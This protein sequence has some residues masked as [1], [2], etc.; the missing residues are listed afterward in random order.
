M[1][2]MTDVFTAIHVSSAV[3]GRIEATAPW[4][5]E[6]HKGDNA[7][8][9]A[10]AH[11][12]YVARG[13]CYLRVAGGEAIPLVGGD[14]VL[15]APNTEYVLG[16]QP[17]SRAVSF[18]EVAPP[19][20]DGV[21]R[22]GGGGAPTTIVNGWFALDPSSGRF[23]D[24][25]PPVILIRADE[26]RS[27]ALVTTLQMLSA[28]LS[29]PAPGSPVIVTRLADILFIQALRA[30]AASGSC[31]EKPRWLQA[32]A[33]PQIG[34]SLEAMH[35][36]IGQPWTL[37]T[38]AS[39]AG[40]SRSAFA[41]R[42]KALLDE[43][44]LEYLTRWRMETAGRLLRDRDKGRKLYAVAKSVGYKGDAAFTR[45]FQRVF[46]VT[47]RSWREQVDR[48]RFV[49]R[50]EEPTRSVDHNVN[51]PAP[52]TMRIGPAAH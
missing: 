10:Y 27:H 45:A 36:A 43:T 15:V 47:P 21:M 30:Q 7:T 35:R 28:E 31:T 12:A 42:F 33:D 14:C 52:V 16:D 11:F 13:S 23:T 49:V 46:G 4:G 3:G 38:L 1:D 48:A 22:V 24:L 41:A 18:C 51:G 9:Y 5:L 40:M 44:P 39:A 8:V 20:V 29:S 32:L 26:P 2:P 25:L 37:A 17:H 6:R 50:N 19:G 34:K